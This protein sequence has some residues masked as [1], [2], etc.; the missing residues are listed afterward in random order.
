MI[1]IMQSAYPICQ[2]ATLLAHP[3]RS[4]M[5][6]CL[7][8]GRAVPAGE[9]CQHANISAQSGSAHLSKL[10]DGG[11]LAVW[12]Q[13]RSRY[14]ELAN[15]GVANLLEAF[16]VVATRPNLDAARRNPLRFARTCYDHLAG[17]LAVALTNSL[18]KRGLLVENDLRAYEITKGGTEF[19]R[20]LGVNWEEWLSKR[21][22]PARQCLDWTERKPH[23]AGSLG[24]AML[25]FF[26]TERWIARLPGS[27]AVRLTERGRHGFRKLEA[28]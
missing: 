16:G 2:I 25:H 15:P 18:E 27:R 9:L 11:L 28:L 21:R 3:A 12:K 13:G 8:D 7:L 1:Q 17:V 5:L 24:A 23:L 26:L 19:F 10:V 20:G 14:F 4:A 6:M 22:Q